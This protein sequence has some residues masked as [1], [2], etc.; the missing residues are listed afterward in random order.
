MNT[1]EG[2]ESR[3]SMHSVGETLDR[4]EALLRVKGVT[5]FA[6]IDHGG[7]AEAVGLHMSP[8]ELLIF[9]D[10]R[11]GTVLM[12]AD[13]R[14]AIDLP[15]KALAWQD[16]NGVVWLSD[17]EPAY[18]AHRFGLSPN[19]VATIEPIG[20]ILERAAK[21]EPLPDTTAPVTP[22]PSLL[23][24]AIHHPAR[25]ALV[26]GLVCLVLAL[27]AFTGR[28]L[29][30]RA[31]TPAGL[32]DT[33]EK[34]SGVHPGFRRNH[35]KGVGAR[36]TF[37]SSGLAAQLSKAAVFSRGTHPV[38]GRFSVGGGNPFIADDTTN[39]RSMALSIALPNGEEWRMGMNDTA[40]FAVRT[41]EGLRDLLLASAPDPSTGRPDPARMKAFFELHPET[42][43]AFET[44][45]TQ[46]RASGF[47]DSTFNGLNAFIFTDPSGRTTPVRWSMVPLEPYAP[48]QAAKD[49][50]EPNHLFDT[51]AERVRL[52][53]LKWR[54]VLTIGQPGDPTNDATIAWPSDRQKID[55]G[56][57]TIDSI[58]SEA[59]SPARTVNFDPLILPDGI[60]PSDDPLLSA[61]SGAYSR[62]YTRRLSEPVS[63]SAVTP[64]EVGA[65]RDQN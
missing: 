49:Q 5:V 6:R 47:A 14:A 16:E 2:F 32:V 26:G 1:I 15:L 37:E 25:T 54:F 63:P 43:R 28:W 27:F 17:N 35:A 20:S 41:G 50:N 40:V 64:G 8:A 10:P 45:K 19:E 12:Q 65:R 46:P 55:A 11:A 4:L 39:V 7:Q 42:A 30:P 58:E 29:S 3:P 51:L 52:G 34:V 33:F 18:L 53:P 13:P 31:L 44:M 59:T 24:T 23:T 56:W 22:L 38:I 9:G 62:S 36:G 61:R 48:S 60:G 57:V 21:D